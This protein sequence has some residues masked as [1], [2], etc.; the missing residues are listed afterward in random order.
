MP[1]A[2]ARLEVAFGKA[3][4]GDAFAARLDIVA[5]KLAEHRAVRRSAREQPPVR[6]TCPLSTSHIV[7]RR[8]VGQDGRGGHPHRKQHQPA[9]PEWLRR[10]VAIPMRVDSVLAHH[11]AGVKRRMWRGCR[12]GCMVPLGSRSSRVDSRPVNNPS[13]AVSQAAK[14]SLARF[15][16]QRLECV[17]R[18]A[19]QS[20]HAL[21]VATTARGPSPSRRQPVYRRAP[22]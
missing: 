13:A 16:H 21:E 4:G 7:G 12:G 5:R 19:A 9:E 11:M 10:A 17:R 6:R 22:G 15:R 8:L 1:G 14:L 18:P 3:P 20:P 2:P